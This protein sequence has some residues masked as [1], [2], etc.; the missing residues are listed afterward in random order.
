MKTYTVKNIKYIE[1][2]IPKYIG[3]LYKAKPY[4]DK[5]SLL[6]SYH[7]YKDPHINY[8]NT[9]WGSTNRT[10]L[11][12]LCSQQKHAIRI[13]CSKDRLSQTRE[14]FKECCKVLNV[15]QV[16]IW[17]NLVFMTQILHLQFF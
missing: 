2:K 10:N 14:L 6:S 4:I 9:E 11:E 5:H 7:S 1:I 17:K 3:L 16:N 15:Y 12:K 13:V 8:G